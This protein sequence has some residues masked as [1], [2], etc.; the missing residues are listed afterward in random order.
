MILS[1]TLSEGV[2]EDNGYRGIPQTVTSKYST[3]MH[4]D[5]PKGKL[6]EEKHPPVRLR[7]KKI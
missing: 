2:Q 5:V 1:L 6:E 4:N 3:W 7:K